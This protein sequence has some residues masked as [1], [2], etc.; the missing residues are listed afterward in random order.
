MDE[1]SA[2]PDR[3]FLADELC[4]QVLKAIHGGI[5]AKD[6]VAHFCL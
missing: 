1:K 5:V 2:H 6:I 3:C 4:S